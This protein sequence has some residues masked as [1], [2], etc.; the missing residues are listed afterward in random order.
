VRER[1]EREGQAGEG[2]AVSALGLAAARRRLQS[3][4]DLG[5]LL[6]GEPRDSMSEQRLARRKGVVQRQ[7][8]GLFHPI[9]FVE[10]HV[11]RDVS[12]PCGSRGD[13]QNPVQ[14]S[15]RL[16]A[17]K[18]EDRPGLSVRP[19][20]Q[21][22][23]ASGGVHAFGGSRPALRSRASSSSSNSSASASRIASSSLSSPGLRSITIRAA[24]ASISSR[25]STSRNSFSFA[26]TTQRL[27][28][29]P[30]PNHSPEP[31]A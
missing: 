27:A 16:V 3:P 30:E 24:A 9:S 25:S 1:Q 15:D 23:L 18:N 28:P 20:I 8:A 26:V 7:R 29:A 6:G 31:V 21:P 4:A 12:R 10:P 22:D 11:G 2:W 5:H 17:S 14:H 13:D 19:L